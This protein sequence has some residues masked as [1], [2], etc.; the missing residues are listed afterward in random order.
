[1][2]K[3]E[4]IQKP[5][6]HAN[7]HD[8]VQDRLDATCHGDES[9]HQPQEDADDD[10]GEQNLKERHA[11]L[12][13]CLCCET[14]LLGPHKLVQALPGAVYVLNGLHSTKGGLSIQTDRAL[15]LL[16]D[17]LSAYGGRGEQAPGMDW[18]T[19]QPFLLQV[20]PKLCL[21]GC[22]FTCVQVPALLERRQQLCCRRTDRVDQ[23]CILIEAPQCRVSTPFPAHFGWVLAALGT[24]TIELIQG[25]W[26]VE[27]PSSRRSILTH[28][29][30][31]L[32]ACLIVQLDRQCGQALCPL[33]QSK[34]AR[35]RTS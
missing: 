30:M 15:E 20:N 6:N 9:I 17:L 3:S 2:K 28:A 12:P 5:Q 1:M 32:M 25:D 10:Q 26:P 11:F 4:H 16:F 24:C 14:L 18:P 34:F 23:D 7:D 22:L 29:V 31:A 35:G 21:S 13:F 33:N 8:C 27:H 19:T